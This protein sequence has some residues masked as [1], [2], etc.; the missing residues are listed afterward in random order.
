MQATTAA[1]K[2]ETNATPFGR[3]PVFRTALVSRVRA[4]SRAICAMKTRRL[5]GSKAPWSNAVPGESG[6]SM[7][8]AATSG[9]SMSSKIVLAGYRQ[10][11]SLCDGGAA[12]AVFDQLDEVTV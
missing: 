3:G 4:W 10:F 12:G 11:T 5:S 1:F 7:V 9:M 2:G 8:P 6:I